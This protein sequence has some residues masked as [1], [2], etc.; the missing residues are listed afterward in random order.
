MRYAHK[1]D[2]VF[3]ILLFGFPVGRNA[4]ERQVL[5]GETNQPCNEPMRELLAIGSS[6]WGPVVMLSVPENQE[7]VSGFPSVVPRV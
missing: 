3:A 7:N 6:V 5:V 4:S 2:A 1:G